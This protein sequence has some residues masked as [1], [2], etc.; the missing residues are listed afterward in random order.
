MSK[1]LTRTTRFG[2]SLTNQRVRNGEIVSVE[3]AVVALPGRPD[4]CERKFYLAC[5]I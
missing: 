5:L 4:R 1:N 2:L 3:L